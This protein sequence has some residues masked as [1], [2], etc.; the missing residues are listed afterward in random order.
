LWS[1]TSLHDQ[2][3][4]DMQRLRGRI[5]L[6][7]GAI[8]PN[9]LSSDGRHRI[10]VDDQS[11][12]LL[13]LDEKGN[14]A[15][16]ARYRLHPPSARFE[17]LGVARSTLARSTQWAPAFQTA[18]EE[19]L[20]AA[21]EIGLPY[22]EMGGWAIAEH[23][24][25]TR[26]FLLSVLASYA[27]VRLVPGA[28]AICPAT[29]RNGSAAVLRRMGGRLF[30]ASTAPIPSYFDA[31]Y[32]CQMQMLR[33]DARQSPL[34]YEET[35]QQLMARL[36]ESPVICVDPPGPRGTQNDFALPAHHSKP[37]GAFASAA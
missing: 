35:V 37:V 29:E 15:G 28:F 19:E 9:D 13:L 7:D 2:L 1:N 20:K 24:R 31:R 23:F 10:L 25:G 32:G 5:Y 11:W 8:R 3:Q 34:G 6:R 17:D 26:H 33:F 16:C 30:E 22:V 14:I 18:V 21:R 12:H 4:A 27:F 36:I